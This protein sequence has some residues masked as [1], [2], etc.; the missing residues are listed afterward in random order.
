MLSSR[1]TWQENPFSFQL[2]AHK[3]RQDIQPICTGSWGLLH[4]CLLT[5]AVHFFPLAASG[6]PSRGAPCPSIHSASVAD[7]HDNE[8]DIGEVQ[9][10]SLSI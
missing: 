5:L 1:I 4:L 6:A 7:P 9:L 8:N 3:T 10:C 2:N